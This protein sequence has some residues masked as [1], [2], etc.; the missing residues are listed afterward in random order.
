MSRPLPEQEALAVP[1]GVYYAVFDDQGEPGTPLSQRGIFTTW[2]FE[3]AAV[4]FGEFE[5]T[6]ERPLFE[7]SGE[8]VG[9]SVRWN[10]YDGETPI[11]TPHEDGSVGVEDMYDTFVLFP[12]GSP[13]ADDVKA[14]VAANP[15]C[16]G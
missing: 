2:T 13:E 14:R 4:D 15:A 10:S 16:A 1:D 7:R 5:C 3:G 11:L 9:Q 8:I 6:E 12:D